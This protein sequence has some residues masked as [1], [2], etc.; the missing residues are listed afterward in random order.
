MIRLTDE[1]IEKAY[2]HGLEPGAPFTCI[3]KAQL[4]KDNK[5]LQRLLDHYLSLA[6]SGD[7]GFWNTGTE[8]IVIECK[9]VLQDEVKDET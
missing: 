7:A 2:A 5:L 1:E 3:A 8:D 6:N 4:K 9:Q